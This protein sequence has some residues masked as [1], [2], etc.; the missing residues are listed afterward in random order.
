MPAPRLVVAR[1]PSR[2]GRRLIALCVR[3]F[4]PVAIPAS[5]RELMLSGAQG[6]AIIA[7]GR[8]HVGERKS[9][10]FSFQYPLASHPCQFR[11][12]QS[13]QT[14]QQGMSNARTILACSSFDGQQCSCCVV[15]STLRS[16]VF[17]AI[18][19]DRRSNRCSCES[20]SVARRL[21]CHSLWMVDQSGS[22]WDAGHFATASVVRWTGLIRQVIAAAV[23]SL[24]M[25]SIDL[26]FP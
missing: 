20:Q 17:F 19:S 26:D 15:D 25:G 8:A 1:S 9:N 11:T 7:R 24:R 3:P 4:W 2:F 18:H 13:N 21:A 10:R 12:R 16:S 5:Q 6:E 14:R 22:A 23:E